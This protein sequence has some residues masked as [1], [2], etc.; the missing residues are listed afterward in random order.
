[1]KDT[2]CLGACLRCDTTSSL[3]A[4][5]TAEALRPSHSVVNEVK[6]IDRSK[7]I[8]TSVR[9]GGGLATSSLLD[10]EELASFTDVEIGSLRAGHLIEE[11][12]SSLVPSIRSSG[13]VVARLTEVVRGRG[14]ASGHLQACLEGAEAGS[15]CCIAGH[16][17]DGAGDVV[18]T[19]DRTG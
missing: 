6:P 3:D 11:V 5:H 14:C 18:E 19:G 4:V 9:V 2:A 7:T 13:D 8:V 15:C 12:L 17:A 16:L 10:R 1:M